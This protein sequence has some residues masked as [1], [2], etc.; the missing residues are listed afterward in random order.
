MTVSVTGTGAPFWMVLGQSQSRGWTATTSSG[1]KLGSSTLIDGYAN[2]WYVPGSLAR[3]P[4][5]I[6]LTWTPQH[7]VDVA[8]I[9]SA[10][11]LLLSLVLI[12]LPARG[13]RRRRKG[14]D[15]S[16]VRAI[17]AKPELR[18]L[19]SVLESGGSAPRWSTSIVLALI[20]GL[21][22]GLFVAPLAG[23]LVAAVTLLELRV[24][25]SR[26]V[27]LAGAL[28][29]LIVMAGYVVFRQHASGFVS[30]INWPTHFGV[31]NSLVWISLFLFA[32]D[33]LVQWARSRTGPPGD[34]D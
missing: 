21:A 11:T 18:T 13:R 8:L 4:L 6:T 30:D 19:G 17:A 23:L 29:L 25:R 32:A 16:A 33:A 28:G 24:A 3:G 34:P 2:G 7:V 20:A 1:V 15:A 5:T 31:A 9:A 27:V 10:A 12:A 14:R 22:T 26:L